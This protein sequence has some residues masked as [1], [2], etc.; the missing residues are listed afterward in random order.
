M[1][2]HRETLRI[3]AQ[4]PAL[5]GHF[6]GRP[7]VPGVVVLDHVVRSAE[8]WLGRRLRLRGLQQ[9]K[10]LTPLLPE[11]A[12]DISLTLADAKLSFAVRCGESLVA[13][14]ILNVEVPT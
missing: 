5:A 11:Q 4:H 7:I 2:A 3:P 6:P 9:A 13:Q 8:N 14:G 12:A 1:Q 10:F